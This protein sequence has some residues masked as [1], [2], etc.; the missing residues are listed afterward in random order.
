MKTLI[1]RR[2][3]E[4]KML[5]FQQRNN[6]GIK[7]EFSNKLSLSVLYRS[8]ILLFM[9]IFISSLHRLRWQGEWSI[10]LRSLWHWIPRSWLSFHEGK[11]HVYF[12]PYKAGVVPQRMKLIS[13]ESK[14]QLKQHCLQSFA[15]RENNHA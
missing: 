12:N 5:E 1:Y 9:L 4:V 7:I 14:R 15:P 6:E 2:Q 3:N 13:A 8:E 11:K 10:V